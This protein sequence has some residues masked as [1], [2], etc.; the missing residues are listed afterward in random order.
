MNAKIIELKSFKELRNNRQSQ[1]EY[2]AYIDSLDK[3]ELLNEMIRYQEKRSEK[4]EL[5][6][7]LLEQGLILFRT[8]ELE[9][10]TDALQALARSYRRHLE[11]EAADRRAKQS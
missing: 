10:D 9:A 11:Y 1:L 2:Q 3:L 4:D 6:H 8:L 5:T 7:E